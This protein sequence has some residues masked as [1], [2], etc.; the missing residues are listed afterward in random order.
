MN[1]QTVIPVY[2]LLFWNFLQKK[3]ILEGD[4][5]W[6]ASEKLHRPATDAE[7]EEHYAE[8]G[9]SARFAETH[10][11]AYMVPKPKLP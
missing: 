1:S 3:E 9:G 2:T 6:Y 10:I 11:K 7:C 4:N 5:R 8:N